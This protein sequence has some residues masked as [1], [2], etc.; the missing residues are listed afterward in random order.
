MAKS[1]PCEYTLFCDASGEGY[2]GYVQ[3][4]TTAFPSDVGKIVSTIL[5]HK[6]GLTTEQESFSC[7]LPEVSSSFDIR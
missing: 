5:P 2:G 3:K 6:A 7:T 4:N 1:P